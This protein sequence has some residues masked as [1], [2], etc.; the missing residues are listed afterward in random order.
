MVIGLLAWK[1]PRL[2]GSRE[3]RGP[4]EGLSCLPGLSKE[5]S[6]EAPSPHP[7]TS[8]AKQSTSLPPS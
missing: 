2:E 6:V 8:A 7:L 4:R 1:S 3:R 5:H